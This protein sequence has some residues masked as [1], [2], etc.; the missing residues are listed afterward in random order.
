ML[1]ELHRHASKESF[2]CG[3]VH[4]CCQPQQIP[5]A[6]GIHSN[7]R[8]N[9]SNSLLGNNNRSVGSLDRRKKRSRSR[10]DRDQRAK[11]QS[12]LL[13]CER[14]I[15]AHC[16]SAQQFQCTSNSNSYARCL[17]TEVHT[18]LDVIAAPK[19]KDSFSGCL[20]ARGCLVDG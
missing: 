9:S 18:R 16:C 4:T 6:A 1:N 15:P 19:S 3:A 7:H 20:S 11:S 5:V 17:N 14:E 13:Y 12:D 10:I 8:V 2:P